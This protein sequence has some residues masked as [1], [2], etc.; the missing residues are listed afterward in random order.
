MKNVFAYVIAATSVLCGPATAAEPT[1]TT[2][3]EMCD[4]S[5]SVALDKDHFV[6]GG[7]ELNVLRVYRRGQP[8]SVAQIDLSKFLD[9]KRD[10][11][12][13]LEGAARV[14]NTI[15][16]I[17]SHGTNSEG[18]VQD[19]RRRFFATEVVPGSSPPTIRPVGK[20]Y[21]KLVQNLASDPRLAKFQ[22][23]EA[24]T[25]PPKTSGALNIEGLADGGGDRLLIGFRNPL[26]GNKA[27]IIPL[28]NPG[29]LIDEKA[30]AEVS[31]RFGNPIELDL[32]GQ[33]IRSIERVGNAYLIVAG[34]I[35]G[36]GNFTLFRW[37]GKETGEGLDPIDTPS[38]NNVSP[39]AL[40]AIPESEEVQ[41]LSDD[42]SMPVGG[43]DCKDAPPAQQ[44]FRSVTFKP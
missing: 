39:E 37:S 19:R 34:S 18:K 4:A 6:V 5:A 11:E 7:D 24:A 26:P 22:L 8:S 27:L 1:I 12:S 28:E 36:K 15:F 30:S 16:W 23:G 9:T 14:G 20:P 25:K 35:D 41:F 29:E 44:T 38:L 32:K 40:F 10:K 43:G 17:S 21:S 13:D 31:A 2:Y 33:G 3:R 42:G